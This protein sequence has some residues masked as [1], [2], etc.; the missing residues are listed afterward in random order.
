MQD[1]RDPPA[2]ATVGATSPA[3]ATR[4]WIPW[5]R[6]LPWLSSLGCVILLALGAAPRE[7]WAWA[8]AGGALALGLF[9]VR[10]A[11]VAGRLLAWSAGIVVACMGPAGRGPAL[12][13][14]G[15]LGATIGAAAAS[16]AIGR[17][18]SEG[19]ILRTVGPGLGP[20]SRLPSTVAFG[21]TGA[22]VALGMTDV[23]AG[24]PADGAGG[25]WLGVRR[26]AWTVGAWVAMAVLL[27]ARAE[28]E[29]HRRR[30]ELGAVE[31]V[32]AIRALFGVALA[33]GLAAAA[34][35]SAPAA[36][37]RAWVALAGVLAGAAAIH[38]DAVR[39][40]SAARH[41]QILAMAAGAAVI[42]GGLTLGGGA[43]PW[44]ATVVTAVAGVLVATRS[45]ALA[46]PLR[47]AEGVWLDAFARAAAE[48]SRPDPEDA[49]RE[50]L[51]ALRVPAGLSSPSP[52]LWTLAPAQR[53]TVDAAGYLHVRDGQLPAALLAAASEEPETTLR[54]DLLEALKVRRPELRAMAQWLADDG[55]LLATVVAR[56][57][58]IE[59]VLILPRI[60]RAGPA[61]LEEIR[62][63][64]AVADR[65][66]APCRSRAAQSR[67]LERAR[68]ADL[69][70]EAAEER[71]LALG[72]EGALVSGRDALATIRLARSATV[73]VY[74]AA[75]RMAVE[76]LEQRAAADA[77]LAVVAPSGV[78]PVPYLA[79][80]HL[81]GA[82]RNRPFVVVEATYAREQEAAR[83]GDPA[84][85]PLALADRGLLV[86]VD[87]GALPADLQRLVAR[88]LAEKRAPWE[89]ADPLE[90]QLAVTSVS[91]PA[92]LVAVGQLDPALASRLGDAHEAPVALPR[93]RDRVE[94]LRSIIV[95]R[96]AREGMRIFGRPVGIEHAAYAALIEYPFPGDDAELGVV[97]QRLVA[98]C[99][100][101]V[102][103]AGD[104]QALRL[105]SG[106]ATSTPPPRA[107]R[108]R[109]S[110]TG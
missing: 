61:T 3:G 29:H 35:A 38:P 50:S 30:M 22:V 31:R 74:A 97:V 59:G 101:D 24:L 32:R 47:P 4:H 56:D 2:D 21:C 37:A 17:L 89:R 73:G 107:G 85:S 27:W 88:V 95:D 76:A 110:V 53:T 77:P 71:V 84:A 6:R 34:L 70:A 82:R 41:A 104:V 26:G 75:S 45:A 69:R 57:T 63:L 5:T 25:G 16:V 60:A 11:G 81:A 90:V 102:V 98:R 12:D 103:R 64:R 8:F 87:V 49:I 78:D 19:H 67:L 54:A 40:A 51:R 43:D 58:D 96:L 33:L 18:R 109:K 105:P 39:V 66:A 108:P 1:A 100:G 20:P 79:R 10:R 23:L 48:A 28:W 14:C 91:T 13:L 80:A 65:L 93:L 55:A 99:A 72:H 92:E 106:A 86:L 44:I 94:D 52:Q 9:A 7:P 15:A 46:Q 62:A 36:W 42:A 68:A 83:W